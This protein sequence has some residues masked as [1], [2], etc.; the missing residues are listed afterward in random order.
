MHQVYVMEAMHQVPEV[1]RPLRPKS[2]RILC[3]VMCVLDIF[4]NNHMPSPWDGPIPKQPRCMAIR[5]AEL[6]QLDAVLPGKF[7][8]NLLVLRL[9]MKQEMI[10]VPNLI[11]VCHPQNAKLE[12]SILRWRPCLYLLDIWEVSVMYSRQGH[13]IYDALR[14]FVDV[15]AQ[16][17][18]CSERLEQ[19]RSVDV[20]ARR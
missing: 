6:M 7:D 2:G 11:L 5:G 14:V 3:M 10:L 19:C 12:L 20:I 9:S 17:T 15:M 1:L 18:C 13:T 4:H 16:N 8:Q